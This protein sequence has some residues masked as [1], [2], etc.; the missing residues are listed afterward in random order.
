[1]PTLIEES[2]C[3]TGINHRCMKLILLSIADV[4][5]KLNV[6][7]KSPHLETLW[8]WFLTSRYWN[9]PKQKGCRILCFDLAGRR[10]EE[11]PRTKNTHAPNPDRW[12]PLQN[13][14]QTKVHKNYFLGRVMT[15]FSSFSTAEALSTL[16]W[17]PFLLNYHIKD[18][19]KLIQN[20][21]YHILDTN[22]SPGPPSAPG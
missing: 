11:K 18:I 12:T 7:S 21:G 2:P 1:M 4:F 15:C 8:F 5:I 14:H 17:N 9:W 3:K 20:T 6:Q 19:L 22:I 13:R 16:S 10:L